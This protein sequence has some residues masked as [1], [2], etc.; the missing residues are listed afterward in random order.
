MAPSVTPSTAGWIQPGQM[1]SDRAIYRTIA[2][3]TGRSREMG[4]TD[5]EVF[6]TTHC[7]LRWEEDDV[8]PDMLRWRLGSERV[9]QRFRGPERPLQP[10]GSTLRE[11]VMSLLPTTMEPT[12]ATSVALSLGHIAAEDI[13]PVG[14]IA[15]DGLDLLANALVVISGAARSI[16][17][18]VAWLEGVWEYYVQRA[19]R[20]AT[21]DLQA[22]PDGVAVRDLVERI[23]S[24]V[25]RLTQDAPNHPTVALLTSWRGL[26]TSYSS[27]E[28]VPDHIRAKIRAS[29]REALRRQEVRLV[30]WASPTPRVDSIVLIQ[31]DPLVRTLR[32]N[33]CVLRD[34]RVLSLLKLLR[35]VTDPH[36]PTQHDVIEATGLARSNAIRWSSQIAP[37]LSRGC[38]LS[39]E[40]LGLQYRYVISRRGYTR[41]TTSPTVAKMVATR[42]RHVNVL[43]EA[44]SEESDQEREREG[45]AVNRETLTMNLGAFD[46]DTGDWRDPWS[47]TR[48]SRNEDTIITAS[49]TTGE[50][51]EPI[52]PATLA[53]LSLLWS[54][55]AFK[56]YFDWLVGVVGP[57]RSTISST[58]KRIVAEGLAS[59][60]YL[61][62]IEYVSLP[63]ALLVAARGL[64]PSESQKASAWLARTCPFVRVLTGERKDGRRRMTIVAEARLPRESAG[65]IAGAVA[66]KLG[67]MS[68]DVVVE[69]IRRYKTYRYSAL[70]RSYNARTKTFGQR[71]R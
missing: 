52:G 65:V 66:Q 53:A 42:G 45:F 44:G 13:T 18:R 47:R 10:R 15:Y 36:R 43:L 12:E 67:Q 4:A 26:L 58:Y 30:E 57:S 61:P 28:Q 1:H 37:Y 59:F 24:H 3:L 27:R 23:N 16:G 51:I 5:A 34:R 64:T 62:D 22:L 20:N 33:I 54:Q 21:K 70:F 31:H 39:V 60:V 68:D 35:G 29:A 63:E 11:R 50:R 25:E 71:R 49:T 32:E 8:S 40:R 38:V 69:R 2:L 19:V 7:R 41:R 55:T 48:A 17:A 46:P 14:R 6:E 9:T 56:R